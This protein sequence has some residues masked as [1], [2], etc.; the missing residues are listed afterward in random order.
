MTTHYRPEIDGLRAVAVLPVIL[1]H[2]GINGLPGGFVGVD[3]FFVISGFLI[4]GII[5]R[6]L[7]ADNFSIVRFY[8]RRARRI[9]PAL[10]LVLAASSVAALIFM[11]PY[12]LQGFGRGLL[13][14]ALFASNIL[15]WQETGY[16]AGAS[17]LNPLL[18]TWT[19]AVEEQFYIIFPILLMML[20]RWKMRVV[21]IVLV[22]LTVCSLLLSDYASTRAPSANF[23]LLPT[24]AWELGIGALMALWLTHRPQPS[25][26]LA[27]G[28][29][30]AGLA[31]IVASVLLYGPETPFPSF[32]T[33]L[34]V[35]GAAAILYAAQPA[36]L[37]GRL[38]SSWPVVGLG[39]ISYSAYLWHQPLF[40]FARLTALDADP[41]PWLMLM[42][43]GASLG[44]AWLS[45]RFVERPFRRRDG[46]RRCAVFSMSAV[47]T[48][49]FITFGSVFVQ[50][51]GFPGRYP[52]PY[53]PL[54]ATGNLKY[55]EYVR[56]AYN[57]LR[58]KAFSA[59]MPNL[60]IVGD[61]FSQDFYNMLRENRAFSGY[62]ISTLYIPARCQIHF[63][64]SYEAIEHYIE[65]SDRE[66]CRGRV[67]S[68]EHVSLI[69]RA[70]VVVF[71][72]SWQVWSAA[73]LS[74]TLAA[75]DLPDEQRIFVIGSKRFERSRRNLVEIVG[76]SGRDAHGPQSE[77]DWKTNRLLRDTLNASVFVDLIGTVC[78]RGCP[79]LTADGDL[80]SYD[81]SHLT[82]AGAVYVGN[83]LF[84]QTSLK[85]FSATP[86]PTEE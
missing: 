76:R 78:E 59:D 75:M 29:G 32:H 35:L 73:R 44:L 36:T 57:Q 17:E 37:V 21:W 53:R 6:E 15:F 25:G 30:I 72:S 12:E 49:I 28:L 65:E 7:A 47:G 1:F 4:T 33:L 56:T 51:A 70:D 24:R 14:V 81:G 18:H 38:L 39:L 66:M 20:W 5:E 84:S 58:G 85:E 2:A 19:L 16:F 50:T 40:A 8:E 10:F 23:F 26:I 67:L 68:Q 69:R 83:L 79:L 62:N 77:R 71:A 74:S 46:F 80:I 31:A 54:I 9:L 42:L 48:G 3:V 55:G 34:P 11:L 64:S 13:G 22:A 43:A 45:W 27:E 61:S 41:Q 63:G 60:M 82:Q 86:R 52:E